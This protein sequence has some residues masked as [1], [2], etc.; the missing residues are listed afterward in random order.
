MMN[1]ST[2]KVSSSAPVSRLD[3]NKRPQKG[4]DDLENGHSNVTSGSVAT[5]ETAVSYE[6]GMVGLS[7]D[8]R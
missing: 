8:V 4:Q 6:M 1:S 5:A 3:T 7:K 2:R